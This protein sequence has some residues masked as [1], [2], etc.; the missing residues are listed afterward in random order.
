LYTPEASRIDFLDVYGK[1]EKDDLK[2]KEK[3]ILAEYARKARQEAIE[4]FRRS[5]GKP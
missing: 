2:P 1:D 3:K 4:A 5:G